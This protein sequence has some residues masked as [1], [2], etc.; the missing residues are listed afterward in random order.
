MSNF[1][2]SAV[3]L[4][5]L[6]VGF[7]FYEYHFVLIEKCATVV[8]IGGCGRGTC[9]VRMS[10]GRVKYFYLPLLGDKKCWKEKL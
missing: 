4:L 6:F 5:M 7:L 8:E 2:M 10:N 9:K 1:V 3:G